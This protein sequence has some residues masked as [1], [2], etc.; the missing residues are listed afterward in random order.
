M[1][2][3]SE[4]QVPSFSTPISQDSIP[5]VLS[6][7]KELSVVYAF[8]SKTAVGHHARSSKDNE[9]IGQIQRSGFVRP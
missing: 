8:G 7:N 3:H 6:R 1:S 2:H 5:E 9:L 4:A